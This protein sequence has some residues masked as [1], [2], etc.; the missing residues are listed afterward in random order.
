MKRFFL[1]IAV[2]LTLITPL[3]GL[4]V[5]GAQPVYADAKTDACNA[6]TN[7]TGCT[8]S[9]G[10]SINKII[11]AIIN[12][13]SF[14]VGV[15][16]VI[17]IIIAGMKYVTSNGDSNSISSAKSTLIY[18]IVG[19]IIVAAAQSIVRLVLNKVG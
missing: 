3:S 5:L 8:S 15:T 2:L 11:A 17:M 16:A 4:A 9:S 12:I 6:I 14:I 13:F 18:A 7:N 19:L 1:K 10:A